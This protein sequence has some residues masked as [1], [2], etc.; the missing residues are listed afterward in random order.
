MDSPE[1][2]GGGRRGEILCRG[3]R[4]EARNGCM[5]GTL[6]LSRLLSRASLCQCRTAA[7][8]ECSLSL[9]QGLGRAVRRRRRLIVGRRGR[10]R[11]YIQYFQ[12]KGKSIG[13]YRRAW[14]SVR[15]KTSVYMIELKTQSPPSK[16]NIGEASIALVGSKCSK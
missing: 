6:V 13:T 14:F 15:S 10:C 11:L 2:S 8:E 5:T 3:G 12:Q 7:K 9:M 16:D 1:L 4:L